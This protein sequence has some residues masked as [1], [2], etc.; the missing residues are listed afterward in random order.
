[1]SN[2][3]LLQGY[4]DSQVKIITFSDGGENLQLPDGLCKDLRVVIDVEDCSRDLFRL[5]LV[6]DALSAEGINKVP[7]TMLYT[8]NAR[9]DRRFTKGS[10]HPLKVFS[11]LLNSLNF[12]EVIIADPHSDVTTALIDNVRVISQTECFNMK[13]PEIK[14]VTD[15]FILCAPDLGAAKKVFD[16][17]KSLGHTDYIQAV[18]IRDVVTGNIVKCDVQ[19]GDLE[20]KDVVIVDDLSDG[21]ASFKFLAEKL[22]TKNCG[23]IILYTTHGIYSKGLDVLKGYIDYIFCYNLMELYTTQQDINNFNKGE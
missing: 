22:L 9:A 2:I 15:D 23:K 13:L 14:K 11:T 6:K 10:A 16:T 4:K 7:L 20:G 8:P 3:Y 18:K 17:V 19:C 21:G 12:S 5:A 1:M